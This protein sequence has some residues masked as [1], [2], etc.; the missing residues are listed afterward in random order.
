[1]FQNRGVSAPLGVVIIFS[2]AVVSGIIILSQ[3]SKIENTEPMPTELKT[4]IK[5]TSEESTEQQPTTTFQFF[6]QDI[7]TDKDIY[8]SSEIV[9]LELIVYS[10]ADLENVIIKAK[11]I[12]NRFNEEK[13]LNI[14]TGANNV[15]FSYQL[16]RCNVCGGIAA[17]E[18]PLYC[19]VDHNGVTVSDSITINIQQ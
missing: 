16:P 9:N 2:A 5:S 3:Y 11:G 19:E 12:K 18:Y 14:T 1:M 4:F 17:G 8:H 15:S 13:I 10:G 6:I 7:S